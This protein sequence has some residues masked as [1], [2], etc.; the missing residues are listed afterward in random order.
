MSNTFC[1]A[2]RWASAL[3]FFLC[4]VK[5]EWLDGKHCV[6]GS[7]TNGMDVVKK[8][9]SYGSNSVSCDG[10]QC[11]AVVFYKDTVST[12]LTPSYELNL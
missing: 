12:M 3:Q 1:F 2:N 4:T 10:A 7:V 8:I 9:E 6:F 5:T 11:A